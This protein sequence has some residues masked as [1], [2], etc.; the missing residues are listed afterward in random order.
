MCWTAT[1]FAFRADSMHNFMR[2]VECAAIPFLIIAV[3]IVGCAW[4]LARIPVRGRTLAII[5]VAAI[6]IILL[7]TPYAPQVS[8]YLLNRW[9]FV[10][11]G[12]MLAVEWRG[13]H[14][15]FALQQ[16]PRRRWLRRTCDIMLF[17][18]VLTAFFAGEEAFIYFQF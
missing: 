10:M 7:L 11:G 2:V 12:V 16:M 1:L 14:H 6:A 18:I 5:A 4:V 9:T 17:Y 13:R 8:M 15:S 3:A